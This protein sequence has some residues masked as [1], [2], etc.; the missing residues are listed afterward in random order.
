MVDL[1]LKREP[2]FNTFMKTEL[3]CL[4]GKDDESMMLETPK[5]GQKQGFFSEAAQGQVRNDQFD[6]ALLDNLLL[7][8]DSRE[9]FGQP[10][11]RSKSKEC[12]V[13]A[14]DVVAAG[15]GL[16]PGA[17][18]ANQNGAGGRLTR[19]QSK[20]AMGGSSN[21]L[22]SVDLV[23]ADSILGNLG[24]ELADLLQSDFSS[25]PQSSMA[26]AAVPAGVPAAAPTKALKRKSSSTNQS[27]KKPRQEKK[28]NTEPLD[29]DHDPWINEHVRLTRGKYQGRAAFVLGKTEKKYQVQ[30]EGVA[31]QLEFYG[32]MFVRPEDYKPAQPKRSRSKKAAVDD[33]QVSFGLTP[34]M[35]DISHHL[36]Q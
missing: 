8:T 1:N 26:E 17:S 4:F 25:V 16:N 30:V 6:T 5:G 21:Q 33:R 28:G 22:A 20:E 14:N 24:F 13:L 29:P 9:C 32:T 23:R 7:R 19:S 18:A 27:Q 31:Y 2:S 12:L 34:S 35:N 3:T 15:P 10:L 36:D 11:T